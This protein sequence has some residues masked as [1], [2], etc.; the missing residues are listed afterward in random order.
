MKASSLEG[1]PT[2]SLVLNT[3]PILNF[4]GIGKFGLLPKLTGARLHV[5]TSVLSE[6]QTHVAWTVR[7]ID[8]RARR[9]PESVEPFE[10]GY[11]SRL[12]R[13]RRD[14]RPPNAYPLEGITSAELAQAAAFIDS[15]TLDPGESEVLAVCAHRGWTAVVDEVAAHCRADERSIPNTGTLGLLVDAVQAGRVSVAEA[16]S[17]WEA[18][19]DWWDYAPVGP[20]ADFLDGRPLWPRC[21]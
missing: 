9:R 16:T 11:V 1:V 13:W 17:H 3:R 14:L 21:P 5:T 10:V 12:K 4:V 2:R 8:H 18:I 15:R 7:D 6:V 19:L 20:F